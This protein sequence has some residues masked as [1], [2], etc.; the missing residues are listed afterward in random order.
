MVDFFQV[1]F[2]H[3]KRLLEFIK[4]KILGEDA[5]SYPKADSKEKIEGAFY[6]WEY[7]EVKKLFDENQE[8]FQ[9][10]KDLKPFDIY[11]YHYDIKKHG[12]VEPASDPHNHLSKKNILIVRGSLAETA[13]KFNSN[14]EEISK[15]LEIGN[16]I[17]NE[18][19]EK[20]P[21]PHLDRK[22]ITAW[23]GLLLVG[24]AKIACIRDN[25]LRDEYINVGRKLVDFIKTYL[26][27]KEKQKILRTCYG[28]S[29][30]NPP[31]VGNKIIYGFLDDYA[32]LIKGLLYLYIATFDLSYLHWARELQE[33]QDKYFWDS[34]NGG[35][36]Y[37]DASQSD[38]VVRMKEDH[39]GAEPAGNSVS[40]Q[41]LILLGC[42]FE[43]QSFKEKAKSISNYF[44][45]VSPLGYAMPEMMSCLMLQDLGLHMLVV[46][47]K[48]FFSEFVITFL[49][50][51]LIKGPDNEETKELLDVASDYY[52]PGIISI[53]FNVNKPEEVTRKSVSQFKMIR[54]RPT[55]YCCHNKQCTLPITDA[56]QL[57]EEFASKY[58]HTEAIE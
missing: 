32:F 33:L 3:Q 20:R 28:E 27:D 57:H 8:K 30:E 34:T 55:A 45:N 48:F 29:N 41:N 25:P 6:A 35:Y 44:S 19:R 37:S 14:E 46:V 49:I 26:Y 52:V 21:R 9:S 56:K 16:G 58:L 10:F 39:D 40:V 36:F 31:T 54:N 2:I 15:L 23:N 38:V 11:S 50:N 53:L 18:A 51:P 5:D 17:L 4:I 43:E 47:G 1:I 42:Y 13:S 24:I 12:N 22:I 7:D